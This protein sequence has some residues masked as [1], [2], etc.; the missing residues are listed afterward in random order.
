[1]RI[2]VSRLALLPSFDPV[3]ASAVPLMQRMFAIL[4]APNAAEIPLPL[5]DPD[6]S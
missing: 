3:M 6:L 4:L 5:F 2:P 1:M